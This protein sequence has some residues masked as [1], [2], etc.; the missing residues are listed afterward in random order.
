MP[1]DKETKAYLELAAPAIIASYQLGI[2]PEKIADVYGVGRG[3]I[4]GL[5][6]SARC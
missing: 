4:R 1:L 2:P 3:A 5:F 6:V